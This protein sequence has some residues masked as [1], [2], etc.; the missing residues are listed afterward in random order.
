M[1]PAHAGP[2]SAAPT[3]WGTPCAGTLPTRGE[4]VRFGTVTRYGRV[5][6]E[7]P[8]PL[9]DPPG[10]TSRRCS[11]TSGR[12]SSS[13]S[14]SFPGDGPAGHSRSRPRHS[15][16]AAHRASAAADGSPATRAARPRS[17]WW[18]NVSG[19][20]RPAG[21][22][23]VQPASVT[24]PRC[25]AAAGQPHVP[26][27]AV[28]HHRVDEPSPGQRPIR[29]QQQR[30]QYPPPGAQPE[31]RHHD[32]GTEA[33]S[34]RS[35]PVKRQACGRAQSATEPCADRDCRRTRIRSSRM[36]G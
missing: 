16:S 22:G 21:T 14:R 19:A 2:A 29:V 7:Q 4:R 32:E 26:A 25:A 18:T 36:G 8:P 1:E 30:C 23:N 28:P 9:A 12:C 24:A 13:R 17:A 15:S 31:A 5:S 20:S 27:T 6:T 11:S 33:V 35:K 3:R 10:S 34:N